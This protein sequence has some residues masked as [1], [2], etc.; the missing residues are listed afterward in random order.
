MKS[1]NAG[2]TL[3]EIMIVIMILGML[4]TLSF[5]SYKKSRDNAR[6]TVCINNLRILQH[7]ADRYL[8]ERPG[9]TEIDP[10]DLDDYYS[11]NNRPE[12]PDH[13]IYS[14]EINGDANA[15]CD[16]GFGHEL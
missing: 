13:G 9:L 16:Y 11:H 12:C 6:R 14:I 8:F 2:F 15:I 1:S 4:A 7:A 3:L 5:P 10:D